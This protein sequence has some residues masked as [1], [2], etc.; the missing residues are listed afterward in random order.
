M[1]ELRQEDLFARFGG[2]EFALVLPGTAL[3]AAGKLL[4][5]LKH[6]VGGLMIRHEERL[7][8]ITASFGMASHMDGG[9]QFA[10]HEAFIKA[11]DEALYAAKHAGRDRVAEHSVD[12]SGFV[13][14]R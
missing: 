3:A 13:F 5:R 1:K 6:A 12:G 4:L 9:R 14:H 10:T 8:T 11:A 7:V 2:E